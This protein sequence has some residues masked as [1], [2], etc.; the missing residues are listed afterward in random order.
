[1]EKLK[2]PDRLPTDGA[3]SVRRDGE[4]GIILLV[5]TNDKE[6]AITMSGIMPGGYAGC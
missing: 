3:V 5:V 4:D 1:M 2:Q 6:E